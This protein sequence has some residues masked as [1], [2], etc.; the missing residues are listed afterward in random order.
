MR[1]PSEKECYRLIYETGMMEHIVAHSVRVSQVAVLISDHLKA[2]GFDLNRELVRA[3]AL[4]HDIT[5]T[6]SFETG[7]NHALTGCQF[8]S[9]RGYAEVGQIVRQHVRLDVYND[10]EMPTEAEIVNYADKRVLHDQVASLRQRL[11]Y[12]MEKYGTRPEY[13]E[14]IRHTWQKTGELENKLFRMLPF[15]PREVAGLISPEIFDAC[16]SAYR[17]ILCDEKN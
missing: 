8:L 15:S 3:S 11:D 10:S 7:E 14:R 4:L 17:G 5:K 16:L 13:H 1:I 2:K 12:I 9:E 6:R